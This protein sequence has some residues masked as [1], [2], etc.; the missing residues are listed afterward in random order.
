[1]PYLY[2]VKTSARELITYFLLLCMMATVVPANLLHHHEEDGH[3]HG[4]SAAVD[5]EEHVYNCG[6]T[7]TDHCPCEHESTVSE[8]HEECLLCKSLLTEN[9]QFT[10][11][12]ASEYILSLPSS[13]KVTLF[14]SAELRPSVGAIQGR[15]PPVA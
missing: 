9:N 4:V 2:T 7:A 5:H 12:T 8:T 6:H 11:L 3:C 15:A 1:M 13:S 14:R 10:P